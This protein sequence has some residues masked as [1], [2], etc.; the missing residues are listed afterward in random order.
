M[1]LQLRLVF[2][3]WLCW[4]RGLVVL[5]TTV[6]VRQLLEAVA[7][8]IQIVIVLVLVRGGGGEGAQGGGI[9]AAALIVEHQEGVI[10]R[11]CGVRVSRLQ[12]LWQQR[13]SG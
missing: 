5:A 9:G 7:P 3:P 10:G 2:T 11:G 6:H 4:P 1:K 12:V 8:L 13:A